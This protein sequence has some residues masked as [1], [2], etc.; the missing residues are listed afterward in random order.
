MKTS[1]I[2]MVSAAILILVAGV[3]FGIAQAGGNQPYD[4][5]LSFGDQDVNPYI[6][7]AQAVEFCP[8]DCFAGVDWQ[9]GGPVETGAIPAMVPEES[10]LKEYGND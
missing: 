10:W 6:D 2:G 1:T 3:G 4:P 5:M 9:T 7:V 8:E